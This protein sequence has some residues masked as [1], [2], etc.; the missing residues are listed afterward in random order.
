[1]SKSKAQSY[2]IEFGRKGFFCKIE[3]YGKDL[4]RFKIDDHWMLMGYQH[5][6]RYPKGRRIEVLDWCAEHAPNGHLNNDPGRAVL[7]K[8]ETVA[9]M[10]KLTFNDGSLE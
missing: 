10:F 1:M 3:F 6:A 2:V 4:Y 7:F 9:T 8:D 5:P